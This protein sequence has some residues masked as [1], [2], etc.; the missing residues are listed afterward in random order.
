M[1]KRDAVLIILALVLISSGAAEYYS[2]HYIQRQLN[3]NLET[4]Y[5][6]EEQIQAANV[7]DDIVNKIAYTAIAYLV[8]GYQEVQAGTQA[9]CNAKLNEA[10][11]T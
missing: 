2:S 5:S 8:A 9:K 1:K 10:P 11:L 3:D 7:A 4:S 6:K